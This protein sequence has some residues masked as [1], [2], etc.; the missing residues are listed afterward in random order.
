VNLTLKQENFCQGVASGKSQHE[1]YAIAYPNSKNWLS[2]SIDE[3]ASVLAK[4]VKIAARIAEL[5]K[6]QAD[7]L[8][9][10][11]QKI[12][13]TAIKLIDGTASKEDIRRINSQVLNK[14]LDKLVAS[15]TEV[16]AEMNIRTIEDV[17]DEL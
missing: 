16:K 12:I 13:Q 17:I 5:R 3:K 1:S 4:D 7:L 15:K 14:L 9:A 2:K 10:N 11:R 6:P 8:E